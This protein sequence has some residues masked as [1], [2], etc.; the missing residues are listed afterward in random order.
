[1][2]GLQH[3]YT[4]RAIT[5]REV[6]IPSTIASFDSV[7]GL[8]EAFDG[9]EAIIHLATDP[10]P[11]APWGNNINATHNVRSLRTGGRK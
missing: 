5:R 3:S 8:A 2:T 7:E 4:L 1:M 6:D 10:S 9:L 11:D